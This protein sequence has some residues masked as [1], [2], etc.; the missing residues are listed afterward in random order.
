MFFSP[1]RR[2]EPT[3]TNELD[4]HIDTLGAAALPRLF[5]ENKI[6]VNENTQ[7]AQDSQE[8]VVL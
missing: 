4:R 8:R 2:L 6:H 7:E 5:R 1:Y 3:V